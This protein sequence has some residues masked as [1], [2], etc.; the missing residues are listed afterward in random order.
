MYQLKR[1]QLVKADLETCWKFFCAPENL[2]IITPK[3]MNFRVLTET[4]SEIYEGLMIGYKISPVLRIPLSWLT[5]ITV[6]QHQTYFVDEQRQGPYK[7]WHHEHHFKVVEGG[8]EMTD[9][10]SYSLPFGILGKFAHWLFVR[11]QLENLFDYRFQK[12]N[13]LLG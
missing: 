7:I 3:Y 2:Q 4:P 10:V 13:E 5:E 8:I 12:V 9:L 6:V 11:K 1:T